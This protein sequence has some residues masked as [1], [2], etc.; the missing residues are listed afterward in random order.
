MSEGSKFFEEKSAVQEALKK[1]TTRLRA[2]G[3][4]YAVVGGMAL[5]HHGVR[6]F[7][8]DVDLLVT[9]NGLK[10]THR[11][12]EGLGYLPVFSGSKNLR[13]TEN[14]VKIEFLVTGD[15]PG[16]GK[17]KPVAFP[18]PADVAVEAGGIRFL[19]LP[20]LIELKLASGMTSSDRVKDLA[21]V[22]ELIK[23]LSLPANLG[24]SLDPFVREKYVELWK[25]AHPPLKRY[26]QIWRS[27]FLTLGAQSLEEII[28]SL[29]AAAATLQVMLA[30]GVTLDPEGGTGD[31][32]AYLIT[33]DSAVAKK[34]DMHE[35]SEFMDAADQHA[36]DEGPK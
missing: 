33:T 10:E 20:N 35:E 29:Q 26:V 25:A 15:Y 14:G 7:T 9:R 28:A 19:K 3:I 16:D 5:F 27:K 18:D 13:D 36:A 17:P 23:A 30:D 34:Y 6:R 11:Q 2:L 31:D 21:D 12:L 4:D 24:D 32:Y 8:E 22:V 1:I